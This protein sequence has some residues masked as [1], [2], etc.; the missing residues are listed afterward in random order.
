MTGP[1]RVF[2]DSAVIAYALGGDHPLQQVCRAILTAAAAGDVELH[3]STEMVQEVVFHRMRRAGSGPAGRLEAV[4]VGRDLVA[5]CVLH[6]FDDV[7]LN[8]ALELVAGSSL[9]GRD[10]VH[11]ATASVHGFDGI[12]TPDR[13]FDAVPG[14]VR[15]DPVDALV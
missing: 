12:V 7:V 4:Q 9:G 10:A 11:A 15:I 2:V 14:L 13:D 1:R 3:A 6:A 8:R 5:A